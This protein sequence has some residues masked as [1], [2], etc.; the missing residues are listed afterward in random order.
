MSRLSLIKF[1]N[2]DNISPRVCVLAGGT[3]RVG[4]ATADQPEPSCNVSRI[5]C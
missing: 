2:F 1:V 5:I 4:S 3:S